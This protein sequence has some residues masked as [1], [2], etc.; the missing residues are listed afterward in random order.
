MLFIMRGRVHI[1]QRN[2][3]FSGKSGSLSLFQNTISRG[4]LKETTFITD[5]DSGR[6]RKENTDRIED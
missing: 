1:T 3:E 6:Y 4:T 2:L 5:R